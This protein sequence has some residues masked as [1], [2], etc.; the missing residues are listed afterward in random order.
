[1]GGYNALMSYGS[2]IYVM[3]MNHQ[4]LHCGNHTVTP[5]AKAFTVKI[6]STKKF[7]QNFWNCSQI[8][9]NSLS[10]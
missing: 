9:K 2:K 7:V 3:E 8:I 10:R 6:T 1:M 5:E 4:L